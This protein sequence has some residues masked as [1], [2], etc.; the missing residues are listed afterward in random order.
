M[1]SRWW[2]N[3]LTQAGVL[4]KLSV[5]GHSGSGGGSS[6]CKR[7]VASSN[8]NFVCLNHCVHGQEPHLFLQ[9]SQR[10]QCS[11]PPSVCEC[12]YECV[13]DSMYCKVLWGPLDMINRYLWA[14]HLP[15]AG[16]WDST[17]T[18]D[19]WT[20]WS[21]TQVLLLLFIWAVKASKGVSYKPQVW[22]AAHILLGNDVLDY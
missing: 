22:K 20:L 18:C 19:D 6:S 4:L 15:E 16:S 14:G 17:E 13:N 7:L 11:S 1:K 2:P 12:V 10:L 5:W 8:L 9:S 21:M 3:F